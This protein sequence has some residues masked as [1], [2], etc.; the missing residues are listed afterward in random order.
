MKPSPEELR[1][2]CPDVDDRLIEAHLERL[3]DAYY[4]RFGHEE[5]AQHLLGLNKLAAENLVEIMFEF[6]EGGTASC[7]ILAYDYTSEFALITGV[8]AGM[9]FSVD[10]G[11]VFTYA[12]AGDPK[13]A[14]PIGPVR[15]RRPFVEDPYRRRRIIDHFSGHVT[16]ASS[17]TAWEAELRK[18]LTQVIEFLEK[19]DPQARSDARHYVNEKVTSRLAAL[20]D[21]GPHTRR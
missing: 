3:G 16:L 15:H 20:K 21:T 2:A 13:P 19:G 14:S 8:L 9:G 7:T 12:R 10:S 11:D 18:Q 17:A 4:D 6:G 1:A 5:I